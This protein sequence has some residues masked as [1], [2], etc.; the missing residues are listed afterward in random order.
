MSAN[1]NNSIADLI[2]LSTKCAVAWKKRLREVTAESLLTNP[3]V[4]GG[5]DCTL[6]VDET[7]FSKRKS[8][9][10]REYP[11]QWIFGGVC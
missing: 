11:R 6:E 10:G 4:I 9:S 3:L 1:A 5:P 7:L 2:G 8:L